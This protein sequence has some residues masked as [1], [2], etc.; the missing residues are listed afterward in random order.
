MVERTNVSDGADDHLK[1]LEALADGGAP[2][3]DALTRDLLRS[4]L[5][6]ARA[7]QAEGEI[8]DRRWQQ[9]IAGQ[10]LLELRIADSLAEGLERMDRIEQRLAAIEA[11]FPGLG[12][13]RE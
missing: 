13:P 2:D 8:E 4:T 3:R 1:W 11:A 12:E 7:A 9:T 10:A 6:S 5:L